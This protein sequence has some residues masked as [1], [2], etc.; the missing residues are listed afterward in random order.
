VDRT[1]LRTLAQNLGV[2]TLSTLMVMVALEGAARVYAGLEAQRASAASEHA[3]SRFHP[4]L[5]WDKPPGA[6]GVVRRGEFEVTL[7]FNSHGLRGPERDYPKPAHTTRVLLL[8]DSFAEGY[9]APE[10]AT[11]R[12][13]LEGLLN[14]GGGGH[15]VINGGTIAYS[16]D[17][18]YLFYAIEGR[19]YQS[20]L[21]L[22]LFYYNDL[23]FNA[24]PRGPAGEGKPYFEVQDDRL[25]LKGSPVP[26][27]TAPR[28]RQGGSSAVKPWHGSVALRLLSNR[29]VDA[30]PALHDVLARVGLVEPVGSEPPPEFWPFGP[31][32]RPLVDDMWRRT[33]FIL[34]ALKHD[35]EAQGARL[36][37]L[38]VPARF[39]VNDGVWALTRSRYRLG[40]RWDR[41][42]VFDRLADICR[43][44]GIPLADPREALRRTEA[45][46][47]AAYY[48]RDVHWNGV[49][50]EVGAQALLTLVERL[51]RTD[52]SPPAPVVPRPEP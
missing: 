6:V 32:H 7:R 35:V 34:G 46:G 14:A 51:R 12:A 45:S 27:P 15:E 16:T 18:E 41:F 47:R 30:L 25:I 20:D 8:G 33:S 24:V 37:V 2:A 4:L 36:G 3:L 11:A 49:G 21:V 29:T 10:E 31:G 52:G 9:Y 23:Y 13:V 50:N 43:E 19:R 44:R 48:T 28:G 26:A 38:Y 1:R 17:Q 22:L 5:G 39:E 40:P 42:V